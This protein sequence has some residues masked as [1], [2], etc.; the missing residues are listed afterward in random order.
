MLWKQIQLGM[1]QLLVSR[2]GECDSAGLQTQVLKTRS[3]QS[4][5]VSRR[6]DLGRDSLACVL[7]PRL[8]I[9]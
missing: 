8:G 3:G 1:A 2:H 9:W 7:I 6:P 5:K 4:D